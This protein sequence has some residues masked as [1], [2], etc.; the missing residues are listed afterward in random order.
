LR[1]VLGWQWVKMGFAFVADLGNIITER[2]NFIFKG[3]VIKWR[4]L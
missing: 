2:G 4:A 3:L 1:V